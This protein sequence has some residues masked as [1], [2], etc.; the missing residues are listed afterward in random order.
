MAS[1]RFRFNQQDAIAW[2]K[3]ALWFLA[4]TLLVLIPSIIGAL[5]EEWKYS[6]ILIYLLNR[7]MDAIRRWYAGK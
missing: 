5:P 7:V 4:P 1:K 2:W 3:N 6:V